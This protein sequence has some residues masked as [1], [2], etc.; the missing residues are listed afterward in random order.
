MNPI[1]FSTLTCPGWS[2]DAIF[3]KAAECSCEGIE[4][5]GGTQGHVQPALSSLEKANLFF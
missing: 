3:T 5:C 1:A 2:I 4:W